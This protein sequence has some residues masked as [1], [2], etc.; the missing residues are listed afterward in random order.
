[1]IVTGRSGR[2]S[3]PRPLK[4]PRGTRLDR[5]ASG[6]DGP[7]DAFSDRANGHGFSF[8]CTPLRDDGSSGRSFAAEHP[9]RANPCHLPATTGMNGS[10]PSRPR[11][12]AG[13]SVAPY[14]LI[15]KTDGRGSSL[16]VWDDWTSTS[17]YTYG[18]FYA[19]E[20]EARQR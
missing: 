10:V 16:A 20:R 4:L 13:Y 8:F 3:G 19:V 14:S 12:P 9:Y 5:L 18:L 6:L 1:M 15:S 17:G 7:V 2:L 11:Q